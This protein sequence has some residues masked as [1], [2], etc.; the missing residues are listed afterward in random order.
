MP[1]RIS[2][3]AAHL[4]LAQTMPVPIGAQPQANIGQRLVLHGKCIYIKKMQYASTAAASTLY[5]HD[6]ILPGVPFGRAD[7]VPTPAFWQALALTEMDDFN[8]YVSPAGSSLVYDVA[9][10][11]LGGYGIKM[12]MNVAAWERLKAAGVLRVDPPAADTIEE[13]LREPLTVEGRQARYRFPRQKAGRLTAALRR[14]GELDLDL[15]DTVSLR[16]QLMLLPGIGPKTASWIVRNWAGADNVAILD[17]H[18]IRAGQL[19]GLFPQ[20]VRLP[21][22]YGK[23]EGLF[24]TFAKA[25]AVPPSLLDAIIWREMRILYR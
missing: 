11:I 16:D 3:V 2:E 18:V 15:E 25:L 13:L 19:M 6:E 5:P 9:F 7:L 22:D 23:L 17:V 20:Q 4:G 10:C 12:E 14:L 24:L 21:K 1:L 8:A